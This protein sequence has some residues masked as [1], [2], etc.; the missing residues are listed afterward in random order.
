MRLAKRTSNFGI[1]NPHETETL[2]EART[3]RNPERNYYLEFSSGSYEDLRGR[4]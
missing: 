2:G 3:A 4:E 1:R